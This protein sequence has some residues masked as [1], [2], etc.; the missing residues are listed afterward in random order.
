MERNPGGPITQ[1][2]VVEDG[3][4]IGVVHIHDILRLGLRSQS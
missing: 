3:R 1:L 2:V 4:P